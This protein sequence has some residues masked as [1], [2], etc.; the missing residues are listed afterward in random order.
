MRAFSTVFGTGLSVLFLFSVAFAQPSVQEVIDRWN[1]MPLGQTNWGTFQTVSDPCEPDSPDVALELPAG[2]GQEYIY[3]AALWIG[4][5]IDEEGFQ[6]PR[7]S[8][9]TD[10]WFNPSINELYPGPNESIIERSRLDTTGCLGN[11]IYDGNAV[12][13]HEYEATFED[14]L[15]DPFWVEQDP[16]DGAHRPLGLKVTRTTY[17]MLSETCE[18]IFWIKYHI[19]NI[20]SNFLKNIYVGHFV[21]TEVRHVSE[22]SYPPDD[23]CGFDPV[24]GAAY[25]CDNDG[26]MTGDSSGNDFVTPNVCGLYY[27]PRSVYDTLSEEPMDAPTSFNWW[28]SNGDVGLDYGPSWEAYC[29]RDSLDLGWTRLYGT[30]VGDEHKYDLMRN[31]EIDYPF[32]HH[33]NH[34]PPPNGPNEEHAW[35]LD[36]PIPNPAP[37]YVRMLYSSGPMG[38]FEYIDQSGNYIYR[39]NP[40]ESFDCWMALVGGLNLH[41]PNNPQHDPWIE[42]AYFDFSDFRENV[43]RAISGECFD[44]AQKSDY[45]RPIVR[46]LA[47]EPVYP[48]P[49]N[50]T[51][52][53]R[54][55]LRTPTNVE[56]LVYDVLGRQAQ[57]LTSRLYDAG[58]HDVTWNAAGIASGIYF[59]QARMNEHVL[60]TQKAVLLK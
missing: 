35:C 57:T 22:Q 37:A 5:L 24:S 45:P 16:V 17:A 7:V 14:T 44:W 55:S 38:I 51:A 54:F 10:G 18:H 12:A 60:A 27:L 28:L 41:D 26:R 8:V 4:A 23:L 1:D 53:V 3:S 59:V 46:E 42:P 49:F 11:S 13:D 56:L 30:P 31:K 19:Q 58:T 48:N 15:R 40:G 25:W 52:R 2:S 33:V 34:W 43:G 6:T 39:L 50:S 20:G 21:D 36:G 32:V 29:D 47:L 9:G